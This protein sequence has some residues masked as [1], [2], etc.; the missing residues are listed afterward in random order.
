MENFSVDEAWKYYVARV[1]PMG[2]HPSQ[3]LETRRAFYSG[4]ATVL[5]IAIRIGE[6]DIGEERG[7]EILESLRAEMG[8][9][10]ARIGSD[11]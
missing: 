2:A 4:A 10:L 11:R 9:F 1:L 6:P 3:L 8:R 5:G 7:V